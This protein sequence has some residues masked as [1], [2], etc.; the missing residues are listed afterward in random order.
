MVRPLLLGPILS[1]VCG[2]SGGN[3]AVSREACVLGGGPSVTLPLLLAVRP[4]LHICAPV[5][6]YDSIQLWAAVAAVVCRYS[7]DD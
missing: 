4:S 7:R 5:R 6:V 3:L 1:D 2:V